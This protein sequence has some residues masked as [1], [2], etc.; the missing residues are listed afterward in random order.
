MLRD[1]P[2]GL[3]LLMRWP[4]TNDCFVLGFNPREAARIKRRGW[5]VMNGRRARVL[6]ASLKD[7]DE[8]IDFQYEAD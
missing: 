6:A 2:D 3:C 8:R 5:I 1:L 4:P 7:T